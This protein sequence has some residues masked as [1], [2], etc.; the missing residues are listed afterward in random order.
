[1]LHEALVD[2]L[3]HGRLVTRA[4]TQ[5]TQRTVGCARVQRAESYSMAINDC[6]DWTNNAPEDQAVVGWMTKRMVADDWTLAGF[7]ADE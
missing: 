6:A 3:H 2:L 5:T 1:M 4:T 7:A